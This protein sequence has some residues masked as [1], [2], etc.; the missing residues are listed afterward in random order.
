MSYYKNTTQVSNVLIDDLLKV[1]SFSELKV[2]LVII[3]RTIGMSHATIK[4][5]RLDK[6]WISQKLFSVCTSL[7]GRAVSTAIDRL[8]IRQLIEV[9]D[10]DGIQLDSREKRR[11]ISRLYFASRLRL[12]P[13][14]KQ[15]SEPICRTPVNT[16]HT[17]KL[18]NKTKSCYNKSQG[19]KRLSDT[20]RFRQLMNENNTADHK[21]TD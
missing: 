18:N 16:V 13:N 19:I 10:V 12:D 20:Q 5:K 4:R 6:A 15:T 21:N 1:I 8:V 7:S 14:K 2:L 11:G 9:T 3:R 17:I